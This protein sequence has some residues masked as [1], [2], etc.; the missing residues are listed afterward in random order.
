[1][2]LECIPGWRL[3]EAEHGMRSG[4]LATAAGVST[5]TLRHYERIGLLPKVRRSAA[6]Y[7]E[8]PAGTLRRVRTI[9]QALALGFSLRELSQ[10]FKE[11]DSG[12]RPCEEVRRLGAVKLAQLE[13]RIAALRTLR[14]RMRDVLFDWDR[15]LENS[16]AEP[17]RLLESLE[18]TVEPRVRKEGWKR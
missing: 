15:R 9:R 18:N 5:D 1:M 4:E 2:T 10:I 14:D 13:E 3:Q 12:G 11:R 7:R 6:N 17:A 8:Y 16:P